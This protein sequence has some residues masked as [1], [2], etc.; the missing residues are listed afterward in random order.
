MTRLAD[1]LLNLRRY[2]S[3]SPSEVAKQAG[4]SATCYEYLEWGCITPPWPTIQRLAEVLHTDPD[5][6]ANLAGV[7]PDDIAAAIRESPQ[8]LKDVRRFLGLTSGTR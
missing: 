1:K 7:V 3:M 8:R 5:L 4:I 2:Y 6:L